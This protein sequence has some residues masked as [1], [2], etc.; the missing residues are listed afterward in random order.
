MTKSLRVLIADDESIIR[1]GLRAILSE[2]GHTVYSAADGVEAVT[3][4]YREQ[5]DI[6]L[7]DVR[8]P[9]R[10]GLDAAAE[11]VKNHPIPVVIL[12]AYNDSTQLDRAASIP[13]HGYLIKPVKRDDLVA[14]MRMAMAAF[15]ERRH[16]V[17]KVDEL[18][19]KLTARKL[20]DRAKGFLM[21]GGMSEEEAYHEIQMRARS[22]RTTM[23]NIAQEIIDRQKKDGE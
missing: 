9:F 20:I 17:E 21:Q 4:A 22:R 16:L 6:A 19:E 3:L 1:M 12:T 2:L 7:L 5:P 13:V 14:T 10:D 8:M 23:S 11:I 18:Q 15:S